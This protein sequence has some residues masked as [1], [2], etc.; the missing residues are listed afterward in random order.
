MEALYYYQYESPIGSLLL[1]SYQQKLV[2]LQFGTFEDNEKE[3]I[4]WAGKY[5]LPTVLLES[6]Q[7]LAKVVQQLE[8]YF[9]NDRKT[10]SIEYT[11]YG[12][13]FQ[14][15]VWQA[16]AEV[17]YGTTC[18]YLDIAQSID[19]PKAVRAVGGANNKNPISIIIPCHRIIGKN[20]KL[21][22]YGGGLDKKEYLL[23]LENAE[24]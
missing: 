21:V 6:K 13:T 7:V 22:G 10:F 3:L 20:G 1:V 2:S 23:A 19:A 17:S 16:L 9:N 24:A 18:S 11:F 15:K 5:N 4:T 8:E 12:T 14:R